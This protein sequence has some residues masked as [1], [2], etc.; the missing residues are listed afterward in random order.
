LPRQRWALERQA[1]GAR[2]VAATIFLQ[3]QHFDMVPR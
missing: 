3:G 2:R 1:R